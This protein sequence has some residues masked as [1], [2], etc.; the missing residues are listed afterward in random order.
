MFAETSR[1]RETPKF[2]KL[3]TS[4]GTSGAEVRLPLGTQTRLGRRGDLGDVPAAR[5]STER[6]LR[7]PLLLNSIIARL[8]RYF[9]PIVPTSPLAE[10]WFTP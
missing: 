1:T 9:V 3:A 2:A 4:H 7:L 8:D 6:L 10:E 5:A